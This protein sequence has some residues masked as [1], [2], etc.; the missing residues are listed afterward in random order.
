M[1]EAVSK[2]E[3]WHIQW[4]QAQAAV[5][6]EAEGDPGRVAEAIAKYRAMDTEVMAELRAMQTELTAAAQ[7]G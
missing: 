2:D 5:Y 6:A 4:I 3:H 1:L 7:P